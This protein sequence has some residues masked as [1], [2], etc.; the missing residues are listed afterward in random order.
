MARPPLHTAT[1]ERRQ[2]SS[3]DAREHRGAAGAP[4]ERRVHR[5]I[6][7]ALCQSVVGL[8][9]TRNLLLDDGRELWSVGPQRR[10]R[11]GGHGA[12]QST[13]SM[14]RATLRG[15]DGTQHLLLD[16][17]GAVDDVLERAADL[18]HRCRKAI[19]MQCFPAPSTRKKFRN[20]S[21]RRASSAEPWTA[22][23]CPPLRRPSPV[24][25]KVPCVLGT[26][27]DEHVAMSC[28]RTKDPRDEHPPRQP[29]APVD[30]LRQGHERGAA[31]GRV[32]TA[33]QGS[34]EPAL[35]GIAGTAPSQ[36]AVPRR[37]PRA[38]S[39]SRPPSHHAERAERRAPDRL[40]PEGHP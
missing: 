29:L 5:G 6:R 1:D 31:T 40:S 20:T 9:E 38:A 25:G 11:G 8:L 34:P 7:R 15:I 10:R 3:R 2:R 35:A 19:I 14:S 36:P 17:E 26:V 39:C 32:S 33:A 28:S 37:T 13:A 24:R 30:I 12:A 18:R 21:S 23:G 27:P 4:R 16:G 22:R